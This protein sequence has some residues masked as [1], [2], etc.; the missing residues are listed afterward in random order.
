MP[1]PFESTPD[2]TFA[3][4]IAHAYLEQF[5][6][7]PEAQTQHTDSGH[8]E[9]AGITLAALAL[10]EEK[11]RI[12]ALVR[13]LSKNP[14]YLAM[15]FTHSLDYA[16]PAGL[17][18]LLEAVDTLE[19]ANLDVEIRVRTMA[20]ITSSKI[21]ASD[22][23]LS[24]IAW[25]NYKIGSD[26]LFSEIA[27]RTYID[28][29][30]I[31]AI[32][33]VQ[34]FTEFRDEF[35]YQEHVAEVAI[36]FARSPKAAR[37]IS[38]GFGF[39][40]AG[41]L[42]V[43]G[44]LEGIHDTGRDSL[45]VKCVAEFTHNPI[46]SGLVTSHLVELF[47]EDDAAAP[48]IYESIQGN[49]GHLIG[50]EELDKERAKFMARHGDTAE[51]LAFAS[52]LPDYQG[53][54]WIMINSAR[55]L[56]AQGDIDQARTI[57]AAAT[58]LD[59]LAI[60]PY[61]EETDLDAFEH[62]PEVDEDDIDSISAY[63]EEAGIRAAFLGKSRY[64]LMT[65]RG[66]TL[67]F[68]ADASAKVGAFDIAVE[69]FSL[70]RQYPM[71]TEA[72][73]AREA[74]AQNQINEY[75]RALLACERLDDISKPA[76]LEAA[77]TA[78]TQRPTRFATQ[79]PSEGI[80]SEVAEKV[81]AYALALA[82]RHRS[83]SEEY[84]VKHAASVLVALGKYDSAIEL[85]QNSTSDFVHRELTANIITHMAYLGQTRDALELYVSSSERPTESMTV[86]K[87]LRAIAHNG[88][89]LGDFDSARTA[90]TE[91]PDYKL[92]SSIGYLTLR[93]SPEIGA[94]PDWIAKLALGPEKYGRS[95]DVKA[96]GQALLR[97]GI[98]K[99]Q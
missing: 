16:E 43:S 10:Q 80:T 49:R 75:I 18:L 54:V 48:M 87:V 28:N 13:D 96:I 3:N 27:N 51:A 33:Q 76:P 31:A 65:E 56:A 6:S 30:A 85:T 94:M 77:L 25:S 36:D 59:P 93:E 55:T 58:E 50:T 78:F 91:L 19:P 1:I 11:V 82:E 20:A 8:Y 84:Y 90:L 9:G 22:P 60:E 61:S 64:D 39:V 70:S 4:Q 34:P 66:Y 98:V 72:L 52:E 15:A 23:A 29:E 26:E 79:V 67:E 12:D 71:Q 73:M 42:V 95:H 47:R 37:Q 88:M 40:S 62:M 41:E 86:E 2:S 7:I 92:R 38:T 5:G 35:Q 89:L 81:E 97:A 21:R 99:K 74:V 83:P 63:N 32:F 24:D 68:I 44:I 69:A 14:E 17:R 45:M 53:R 46:Y 57:L